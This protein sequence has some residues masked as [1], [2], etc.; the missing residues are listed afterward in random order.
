MAGF[1]ENVD[2]IAGQHGGV[3]NCKRL[4]GRTKDNLECPTCGGGSIASR[5]TS[6]D[7]QKD[8]IYVIVV[9]EVLHM[10]ELALRWYIMHRCKIKHCLI[11]SKCKWIELLS[12]YVF[13]SCVFREIEKPFTWLGGEVDNA[14][15]DSLTTSAPY[16]K[17]I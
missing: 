14:S 8:N 15:H 9:K 12:R 3:S 7:S 4:W 2:E 1:R 13:R 5:C 10:L 11:Q 16:A 6:T 17:L